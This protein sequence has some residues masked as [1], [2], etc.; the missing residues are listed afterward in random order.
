[1]NPRGQSVDNDLVNLG[2][3]GIAQ[4]RRS[5]GSHGSLSTRAVL[6][7][8][9]CIGRANHARPEVVAV[10]QGGAGDDRG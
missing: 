9:N 10:L 1:M 3:I 4:T 2:L 6:I 7:R 5:V 8:A